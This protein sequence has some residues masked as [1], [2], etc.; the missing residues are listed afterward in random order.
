MAKCAAVQ[1]HTI[2]AVCE[3]YLS[4]LH[5]YLPLALQRAK[6]AC[7]TM[8]LASS[9]K[10]MTATTHFSHKLRVALQQSSAS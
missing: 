5:Y 10:G 2:I 6:Q 1:S 4:T 8:V 9:A 3:H 7:A